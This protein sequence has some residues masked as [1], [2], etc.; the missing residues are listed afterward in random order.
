MALV[1]VFRHI[2]PPIIGTFGVIHDRAFEDFE[3]RL[4]WLEAS[5]RPVERFDP[6]REPG[7]VATREPVRALLAR[8][9]DRCLPLV[10]VDDAVVLSG[11]YPS[12][13]QL[14]RAVGRAAAATAERAGDEFPYEAGREAD[15]ARGHR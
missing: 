9:G 10:L 3:E 12:R 5:G 2:P 15:T 4:D 11:S 13:G 7:E 14:A 8:E 6:N 1:T